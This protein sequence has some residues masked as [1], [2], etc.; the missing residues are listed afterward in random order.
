M[1]VKVTICE[2][3]NTGE[4]SAGVKLSIFDW[5]PA[6]SVVGTGVGV[7]WHCPQAPDEI[8]QLGLELMAL[9]EKSGLPAPVARE[10]VC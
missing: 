9:V 10:I 7:D 1:E 5:I 2:L 8:N 3:G 4:R 6:G